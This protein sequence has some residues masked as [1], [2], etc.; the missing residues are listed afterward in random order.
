MFLES[1]N[2]VSNPYKLGLLLHL[3]L[4]SSSTLSKSLLR[5]AEELLSPTSCQH[6]HLCNPS[7]RVSSCLSPFLS[8]SVP[9]IEETYDLCK[10]AEGNTH[11]LRLRNHK[12]GFVTA[13][14]DSNK[15]EGDDRV[16]VKGAWEFGEAES[17][18]TVRV[19]RNIGIPP[20]FR[21]R[22][23]FASKNC[24]R[25]N[26]DWHKKVRTYRGHNCRAAWS[27]LRYTPHYRSFNTS[28]RVSGID[29]VLRGEGASPEPATT[30][31]PILEEVTVA[32][33]TG[34]LVES[35]DR[36]STPLPDPDPVGTLATEAGPSLRRNFV[37]P[38]SASSSSASSSSEEEEEEEEM[39]RHR[40]PRYAAE[41]LSAAAFGDVRGEALDTPQAASVAP[42]SIPSVAAAEAPLVSAPP[43]VEVASVTAAEVGSALPPTAIVIED[44]PPGSTQG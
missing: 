33:H 19:P 42:A 11:Y 14:E 5:V 30:A 44:S 7:R 32:I 18:T 31:V 20:N 41:D 10:S 39:L 16:F 6:F 35:G 8:S 38:S 17:S 2:S 22:R 12:A 25:V 21:Q 24:W 3:L 29:S 40:R 43:V 23:E 13:L 36:A 27:L 34:R 26:T 28:R 4:S 37:A 15:Y 9:D 1:R